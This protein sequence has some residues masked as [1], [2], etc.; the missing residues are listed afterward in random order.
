MTSRPRQTANTPDEQTTIGR[1]DVL[2]GLGGIVVAGMTIP[3]LAACGSDAS[4]SGSGDQAGGSGGQTASGSFPTVD[5]ATTTAIGSAIAAGEI[6][7]GG[8]KF[9]A[10]AGIVIT[11]PTQGSYV[12]LSTT[13]THQGHP[14]DRIGG[15]RLI[16]SAHGSQFDPATGAAV[17]GPA[18]TDLPKKSVTVSGASVTL[19]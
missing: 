19:A 2:S 15:G 14:I 8:A 3:W 10:D 17:V 7:V 9:F 11:Q 16:C 13:C 5:E 18:Q 12:A 1:R 6:P 4:S